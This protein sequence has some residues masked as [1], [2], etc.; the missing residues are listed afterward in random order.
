MLRRLILASCIPLTIGSYS[1]AENAVI[2]KQSD[3][4]LEITSYIAKYKGE[5]TAEVFARSEHIEHSV[6]LTNKSQKEIV[7]VRIG[8]VI[9]DVFSRFLGTSGGIQ[10]RSLPIGKQDDGYWISRPYGA[11][12]FRKYGTGVA[13]VDL[14]RFSDGTLWRCDEDQVLAELQKFESRLTKEDLR[15]KNFPGENPQ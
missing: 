15:E 11:F 6:K 2:L 5:R 1:L 10:I 8:L 12:A 9:F 4:P 7:A 14:V 3:T 13:Y